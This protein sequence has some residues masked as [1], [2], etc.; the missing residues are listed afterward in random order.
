LA[1]ESASKSEHRWVDL[2]FAEV[3]LVRKLE[4]LIKH[5]PTPD[6]GT[7]A[8]AQ[9]LAAETRERAAAFAFALYPAAAM[10]KLP[11]GSEGANDLGRIATPILSV[12][13]E[14]TW[15]ERGATQAAHHP[16]YDA[17]A[18]V[19]ANLSGARAERARQFFSWCL[20]EQIKLADPAGLEKEIDA[21]AKLLKKQVFA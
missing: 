14:V 5:C 17:Y 2:M 1:W 19:L 15:S 18:A 6:E 11:V 16:G 9:I 8:V 7:Q 3:R 10:G 13:A 12:D 4:V 20:T 21:C